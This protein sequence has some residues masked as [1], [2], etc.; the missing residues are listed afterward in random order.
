MAAKKSEN[1]S[2]EE[3]LSELERVVSALDSGELPLAD[4]LAHFEKGVQLAAAGR[5]KLEQAQQRVQMLTKGSQGEQ[6]VDIDPS[7]LGNG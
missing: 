7:D 3:T 4:A 2:F 6:L 5:A 1:V